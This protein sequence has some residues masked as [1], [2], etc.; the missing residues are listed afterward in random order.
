MMHS[1]TQLKQRAE[2][3]RE[4]ERVRLETCCAPCEKAAAVMDGSRAPVWDHV[5]GALLA[6]HHDEGVGESYLTRPAPG[7]AAYAPS[8]HI[9]VEVIE[10]LSVTSVA[11]LWQDAT[12][13]R[14]ADQVWIS[15]RARKKGRCA[16]S[17]AVIRRDDF[18][19]KPRV[20]S[21]IPA[22]ANAMILA[23][24]IARMPSMACMPNESHG[25]AES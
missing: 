3:V 15:C 13:C 5:I 16:L 9:Q 4:D 10:R 1:Q 25:I 14:Y 20:R 6:G 22:N 7:I 12:R 18:V 21:A 17:G 19:Y 11:I 23:S 8:P 24:V 2:A